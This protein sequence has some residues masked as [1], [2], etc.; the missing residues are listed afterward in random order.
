MQ[1]STVPCDVPRQDPPPLRSARWRTQV[2]FREE[3]RSELHAE[4][5]GPHWQRLRQEVVEEACS[6]DVGA[7]DLPGCATWAPPASRVAPSPGV[8]GR[9]LAD[10]RGASDC[11]GRPAAG[12][13]RDGS[14]GP[15]RV[16][17]ERAS[18]RSTATCV[19]T[20]GAPFG[21]SSS[22]TCGRRLPP[23]C[24]LHVVKVVASSWST[25]SFARL[26]FAMG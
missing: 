9:R 11:A 22:A 14:V 25:C 13:R 7:W 18:A 12:R 19:A 10:S 3:L 21:R 23:R 5:S 17:C 8:S 1:L 15:S 26:S 2:A 24:S 6:R 20:C 16:S 4:L